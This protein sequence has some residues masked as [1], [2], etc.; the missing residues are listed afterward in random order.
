[1]SPRASRC[2]TTPSSTQLLEQ[3]T[4]DV[5]LEGA[6]APDGTLGRALAAAMVAA[7]DQTFRDVVRE[8]IGKRD[9]IID[10][11]GRRRR[12]RRSARSVAIARR[13]SVRRRCENRSRVFCSTR[14]L[15]RP[16]WP[17]LR[18]NLAAGGK[19]DIEP[20]AALR[21]SGDA[22]GR[23]DGSSLSAKSSCTKDGSRRGNPS[24]PRSIKDAALVERLAASRSAS[25]R[26]SSARRAVAC[27]DRSAAL[28]TV[29][30]EVLE[31]YREAKRSAAACSITT[32]SSTR[33]CALL[34]QRRR[35]LG[36]LQA[37][38]RHRS[39][40]DRRG[41]GHQHEAMGRSCA[42]SPTEFTAGAGARG[43]S[44]ARSSRSATRSSRS[45]RSRTRRPRNSPRC[46][47]ISERRHTSSGLDFVFREFEHSFRSGES[48]LGAVD[49]VFKREIGGERH[50][51]CRRLP[52]ASGAAR[53][54]AG[55]GRDLGADE[56]GRARARSKA[57]TRR[58]TR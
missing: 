42:S 7:A 10:A 38:S 32:T 2:S 46:G 56:A 22:A 12:S 18:D 39:P 58:S 13:R 28:L 27:R 55:R 41:A 25:A 35:R 8:A 48:I 53:R 49:L 51:R 9:T 4:L 40:A 1:M 43:R 5:L 15:C 45:F 57:G 30:Y 16:E 33:R 47:A 19:T 17:A 29:A 50:L 54:A 23:R 34:G 36:A 3:L 14:R 21:C 37:R 6:D 44:R 52:A 11:I 31:R 26:C 20:G 24:S